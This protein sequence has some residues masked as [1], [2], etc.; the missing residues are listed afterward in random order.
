M[1]E[2]GQIDFKDEA[3]L[4]RGRIEAGGMLYYDH[5][6]KRS[7]NTNQ[8]LE[9]LSERRDYIQLVNEARTHIETLAAPDGSDSASLLAYSGDLALAGR[10]VS[11]SHNQECFRFL[12]D[13]MLATGVEK[14]SAMGYGNAINALSD[15]EGGV[16]KYFSQR[17]AQ[18]TNPPLDSIREAEGMTLRVALGTK[19]NIGKKAAR[20]IVIDSP[21]LNYDQM[22]RICHQQET[23]IGRFSMLYQPVFDDRE[24]NQTALVTAIDDICD[25]VEKFAADKGGIAIISDRDI[26]R[27]HAS[28]AMTLIVSA[29]NQ[30]LIEAGL[31]LRVSLIVESGQICSSHH[32][33]CA[34]GL[35][36]IHI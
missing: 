25:Q 5:Q 18:V 9:M 14:V 26:S 33:A 12:M 13:P 17:F 20:Q 19:P 21:V 34:L 29:I 11:Y 36:L 10:Y 3:V 31:R 7:F 4:S 1:S 28:I 16:A 15:N 6:Q 30:R 22:Q 2:A 32:I 24:A 27:T 8:A 23:P 35:S